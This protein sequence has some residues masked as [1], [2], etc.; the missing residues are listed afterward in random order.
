MT[1]L[2]NIGTQYFFPKV[3][4]TNEPELNRILTHG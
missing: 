4:N 3:K 1:N 2:V